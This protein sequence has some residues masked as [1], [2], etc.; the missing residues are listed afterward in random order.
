MRLWKGEAEQSSATKFGKSERLEEMRVVCVESFRAER[1]DQ[2]EGQCVAAAGG[3]TAAESQPGCSR[4][5][6]QPPRNLS[7]YYEETGMD[8]G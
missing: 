3:S 6:K 4:S 7:S 8:L 2:Q 5:R 1:G